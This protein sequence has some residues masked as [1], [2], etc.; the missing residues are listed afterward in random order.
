MI[1]ISIAVSMASQI[2][3]IAESGMKRQMGVKD[4][5]N[6]IPGHGGLMDRFDGMLGA[7][8]FLLIIGQAVGFPPGLG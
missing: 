2:G 4:S 8:L 5:S 7:S 6:L 1:G 3:D